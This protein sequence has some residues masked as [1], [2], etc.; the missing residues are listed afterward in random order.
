MEAHLKYFDLLEL[1]PEAGIEDVRKNYAYLKKLYSGDSI[2]IAALNS[3]FSQDLRQDFLSRLDEAHENLIMLLENKKPVTPSQAKPID[4]NLQVWLSGI[5][6]FSGA[7]LKS[8][9]EKMGIDLKAIF[10]VTRIQTNYLEDIENELFNS[11]K[12]EVYL[13][14]YLIEYTRFLALDTQ[15][16]LADYLPRYRSWAEKHTK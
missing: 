5:N 2:E 1:T 10:A 6:C 8:V 7:A 9:R 16:I 3:D 13:K 15:K 4:E 11:F 14:S 12:A